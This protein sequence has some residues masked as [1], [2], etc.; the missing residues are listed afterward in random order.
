MLYDHVWLVFFIS[1]F[2]HSPLYTT[3]PPPSDHFRLVHIMGGIMKDGCFSP[4]DWIV[5][6]LVLIL[7]SDLC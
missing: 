4:L 2:I 3:I 1:H 7:I 6:Y 5:L